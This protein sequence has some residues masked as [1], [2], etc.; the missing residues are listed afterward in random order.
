MQCSK[1]RIVSR[2]AVVA[3]LV[4]VCQAAMA[5]PLPPSV[6]IKNLV[7]FQCHGAKT[8]KQAEANYAD[9]ARGFTDAHP[10]MECLKKKIV[11]LKAAGK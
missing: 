5:D 10:V 4:S 9:M 2:V 6:E 7:E 8:L 11:E 1:H 3:A